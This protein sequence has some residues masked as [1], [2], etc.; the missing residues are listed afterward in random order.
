VA[1]DDQDQP[2]FTDDQ[3]RHFHS[4]HTDM[5]YA[6]PALLRHGQLSG[7]RYHRTDTIWQRVDESNP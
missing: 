2:I 4:L 6:L 3:L 5:L 7:G 1:R